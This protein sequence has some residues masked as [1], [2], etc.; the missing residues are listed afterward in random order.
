[1]KGLTHI[2][3]LNAAHGS[4]DVRRHQWPRRR[5]SGVWPASTANS[6]AR[7]N[8]SIPRSASCWTWTRPRFQC[9]VA[10]A[11][12]GELEDGTP[13]GSE[14]GASCRGAVPASGL[15]RDQFDLAQPG[16]GAVLQQA[17]GLRAVDQGR[18]ASREHDAVE[19]PPVPIQ[20]GATVAGV[21]AYNLGNLW[22]RLMLPQRIGKW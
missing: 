21:I 13:S 16:G 5:T 19:L 14:G 2:S 9:T 8:L 1:M 12:G 18:Q 10:G 6:S 11:A 4:S 15:H 20:R 3:I 22:R 7:Q 17:R